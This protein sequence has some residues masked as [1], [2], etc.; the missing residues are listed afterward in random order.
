MCVFVYTRV[1]FVFLYVGRGSSVGR[2]TRCGMDGPGIESC[3]GERF[4]APV[5]T[6]PGAHSVS[7]ALSTGSFPGVK[8]PG[9]GADHPTF[10][11]SKVQ[12]KVAVPLL[13]LWAFVAGYRAVLPFCCL[14]VCCASCH[15]VTSVSVSVLNCQFLL[16]DN[17]FR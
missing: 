5:Q 11:R 15:V 14:Y 9:R 16:D 12:G 6:G 13:R 7:C 1:Y 17:L 8:R 10:C 2:A 3:I 4:S